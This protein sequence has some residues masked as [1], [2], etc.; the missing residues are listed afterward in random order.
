VTTVTITLEQGLAALALPHDPATRARL[1]AFVEL[2]AKWNRVYNLTAIRSREQMVTHHLLDSLAIARHVHG[3]RVLD[4][5]T[6]GGLPGIPLAIVRPELKVTLL[7]SNHKKT[8]FLN[9]VVAEL[10]LGNV[11][12][13]TERIEAWTAA[14]RYQ[15]I[16]SRAFAE[17]GEFAAASGRLLDPEGVMLAMKGVHPHEE[18]ARLP[19]AFRVREVVRLDVPGLEAERH[20]VVLELAR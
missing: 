17:L 2:L 11:T 7:D 1:E 10:R 19:T 14:E 18:I 8:A 12:V 20:L 3:P 9:Q 4:V 16:V 13:V 5:G 15:T 6:G